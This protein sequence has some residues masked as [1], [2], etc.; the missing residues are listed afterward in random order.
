MKLYSKDLKS[1]DV[2]LVLVWPDFWR[3][4]KEGEGKDASV[5]TDHALEDAPGT[6]PR[7]FTTPVALGAKSLGT[8]LGSAQG[9]LPGTLHPCTWVTLS[10]TASL[11]SLP[12]LHDVAT[13][14][15][16]FP[17]RDTWS[18]ALPVF[19]K[20]CTNTASLGAATCECEDCGGLC[21]GER[22][23][24]SPWISL[25]RAA[26]P[27]EEW[28]STLASFVSGVCDHTATLLALFT[29]SSVKHWQSWSVPAPPASQPASSLSSLSPEGAA[30]Q[31]GWDRSSPVSLSWRDSWLTLC[32]LK[33][34]QVTVWTSGQQHKQAFDY[35]TPELYRWEF[36]MVVKIFCGISWLEDLSKGK[37]CVY[38]W[39]APWVEDLTIQK[40]LCCG[41][42]K[43][44]KLPKPCAYRPGVGNEYRVWSKALEETSKLRNLKQECGFVV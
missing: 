7:L 34:H 38:C 43:H 1:P 22:K 42:S 30:S 16:A 6:M 12:A 8:Q 36:Q 19:P 29:S 14:L 31:A 5:S 13:N 15:F 24:G 37:I 2:V 9:P 11:A 18:S 21:T 35:L 27:L 4:C 25:A 17:G 23:P 26:L 44:R 28:G 10:L 39:L 3:P 20:A 32:R 41:K 40:I 33:V